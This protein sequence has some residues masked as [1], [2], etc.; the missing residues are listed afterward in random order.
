MAEV[1]FT[2]DEEESFI[3]EHARDGYSKEDL[4]A[5]LHPTWIFHLQKQIHLRILGRQSLAS[6]NKVS[7]AFIEH[8]QTISSDF[9]FILSVNISIYFNNDEPGFYN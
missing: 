6:W 7:D 5:K 4:E 9:T 3:G 2:M 8:L 1:M